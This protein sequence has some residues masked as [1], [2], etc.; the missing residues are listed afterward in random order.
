M[1]EAND[2]L[3]PYRWLEPGGTPGRLSEIFCV[4]FFHGL[5]PDEVLSRFG[6]NET[7]EGEMSFGELWDVVGD[8]TMDTQGGSGSGHVGARQ[9]GEWTVALEPLG[10][11]AMLPEYFADYSRG[12]EMVVASRHDYA[13][14]HF[15][16]AVDGE[17]V[18]QFTPSRPITRRGTDPDR[19][20]RAMRTVGFLTDE[21]DDEDDFWDA[22][23]DDRI[24]RTFALAAEITGL[25][26]TPGLLDE[27]WLVGPITGR[28]P[29]R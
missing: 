17:A 7:S 3:A 22:L 8:F 23:W 9:I 16:Y 21:P 20:N 5:G 15:V 28:P 11:F 1:A 14:D 25:S 12:C 18:T 6:P 2:P 24:A 4:S 19:L 27:P 13:E 26:F 10:W 29:R